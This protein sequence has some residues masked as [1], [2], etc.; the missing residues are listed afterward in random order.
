MANQ[1]IKLFNG[2]TLSGDVTVTTIPE[3]MITQCPVKAWEY[4]SCKTCETCNHFNGIIETGQ[5]E[6]EA[7][8]SIV[9]K[10]PIARRVKRLG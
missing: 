4:V 2:K 5:G 9:C 8:H 7:S 6:W 10:A 1:P 3:S